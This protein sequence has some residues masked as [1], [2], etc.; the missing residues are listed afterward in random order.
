[1]RNRGI[2]EAVRESSLEE[3]RL[4]FTFQRCK[5]KQSRVR[6]RWGGEKRGTD[7]K[8][9]KT[10]GAKVGPDLNGQGTMNSL[11]GV[12]ACLED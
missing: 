2:A 7:S 1:M 6:V 10:T 12:M 5:P 4:A 3:V 11:G 9:Q 8:Q